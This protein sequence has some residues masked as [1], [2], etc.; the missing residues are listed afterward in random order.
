[1]NTSDRLGAASPRCRGDG[2]L[3]RVAVDAT[4]LLDRPTGIGVFVSELVAGLG[5]RPD[6]EVAAFAV[7]LRGRSRLASVLPPGVR[8]ASRPLPAR[9]A[10]RAWLHT[11]QPTVRY[12][13]GPA[14]VVHGPNYVVPPGGSA[15]EV[16]TV[17]DLSA[18]HF[19][20]MCTADVLQ[21]PPLLE[22]ALDRGAWVHTISEFV[23]DEVR[24]RFPAAAGRIVAV[25]L[26]VDR[27]A[28]ADAS[29]D[30]T[31]GRHLAGSD[32]YV[33]ALGTVEPRKDLTTLVAAFDRLAGDDPDV[34]LVIAGPDGIGSAALVEACGQ[35][36][37]RRRIVRLGWVD[38]HQRLALLRGAS[39]LAYAGRY[40]GFGLVPLEAV[41]AGT[42]VVATAVGAIPEVMDDGAL[43]VDPNDADALAQGLSTVLGD[44]SVA[45]DLVA[46]GNARVDHFSWEETVDGIVDLYGTALEARRS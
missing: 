14:D 1:M 39:V 5:R 16:V 43:L 19:P 38:H 44:A 32:R 21:W 33:L 8:V 31:R 17:S 27:P 34:R 46:R 35:A 36:R 4:A 13:A 12:L 23:A 6:V 2:P 3:L 18:L 30:A 7:S 20:E 10:R 37:H 40:E 45:A 25:P 22:R 24:S 11:D 9:V 29:T 26:A 42:P 28:P 15:A 41:A